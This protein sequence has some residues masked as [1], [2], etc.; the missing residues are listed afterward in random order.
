MTGPAATALSVCRFQPTLSA[1]PCGGEKG[2]GRRSVFLPGKGHSSALETSTLGAL[3]M[4]LSG[5]RAPRPAA[6]STS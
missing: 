1:E 3:D 2:P 6:P 5:H 4:L